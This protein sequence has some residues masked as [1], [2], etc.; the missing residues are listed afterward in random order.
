M[1]P[2]KHMAKDMGAYGEHECSAGKPE[3]LNRTYIKYENRTSKGSRQ[4]LS[5][6][7]KRYDVLG[8][9]VKCIQ[10]AYHVRTS[11]DIIH[12]MIQARKYKNISK[13]R[14]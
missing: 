14:K 1:P 5:L 6:I 9:G 10:I 7:L 11:V 4:Q 8:D 13:V 3:T 2:E 12:P